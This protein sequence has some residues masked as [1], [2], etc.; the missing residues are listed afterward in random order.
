M[1][2]G[3]YQ[4]IDL[5]NIA[6]TANG[7]A[8]AIGDKIYEKVL[9]AKTLPVLVVG[10]KVGSTEKH[11][12]FVNF[13]AGTNK[14]VGTFE[15]VSSTHGLTASIIEIDKDS[16]AKVSTVEVAEYSA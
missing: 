13:Q 3:G 5:K 15:I 8:V 9:K 4:I 7:S 10:L 14:V 2:K 6:I 1:F 11:A 12:A 16:K